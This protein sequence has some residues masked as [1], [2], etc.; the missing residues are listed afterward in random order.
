M[1]QRNYFSYTGK[2]DF[3]SLIYPVPDKHS[4]GIHLTV[5][6]NNQIRF[7]PDIEFVKEIDYQV[8]ENLKSKFYEVFKNFGQILIFKNYASYANIRPKIINKNGKSSDFNFNTYDIDDL[9]IINL[10]G[11]ENLVLQS[12]LA[13][14]KWFRLII[15]LQ[16]ISTKKIYAAQFAKRCGSTFIREFIT[17]LEDF[18]GLVNTHFFR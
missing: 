15:I 3:S 18:D 2:N 17:E 8:N 13:L 4:L 11:I 12:I 16:A 7:G 9:K 14:L 6:Q 5:D 10:F 1:H